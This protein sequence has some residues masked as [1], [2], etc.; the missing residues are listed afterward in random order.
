MLC[1]VQ[2]YNTGWRKKKRPEIL[3]GIMQQSNQN[4]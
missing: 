1:G 2:S 3:Q 4:K